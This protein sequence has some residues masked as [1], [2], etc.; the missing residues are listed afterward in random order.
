MRCLLVKF[1]P[2]A[3]YDD[4]IR[5]CHENGLEVAAEYCDEP[6]D[7]GGFL[8]TLDRFRPDFMLCHPHLSGFASLAGAERGILV[9]HWMADKLLSKK[10]FD[11]LKLYDSD[12]ILSTCIE[13]V[14]YIRSVGVKANYVPNVCNIN[15]IDYPRGEAAYGV[16]FVGTVELGENN[17]Y[18]HFIAN[19]D[20]KFGSLSETHAR[21]AE[22]WKDIFAR[23]LETQVEASKYSRYILPEFIDA[24]FEQ[25]SFTEFDKDYILSVLAKEV[26]SM[27]R[28]HF[29]QAVPQLDAFGPEDWGRVDLPN[30]RYRGTCD[31]YHESGQVFARSRINLAVTRVYSM[32]G[33]SDRIFNVLRAG[34]FL[35]ANRQEPLQQMFREGVHLDAY[36]TVEELIDKIRY[37][38]DHPL[39]RER[40][41]QCGLE[42]VLKNHTFGSRIRRILDLLKQPS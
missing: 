22:A 25:S 14:K 20:E 6:G 11:T 41:A 16:S 30:V 24:A 36:T 23:L 32:D 34:G 37:Y 38:E 10:K 28:R 35:L 33:L 2:F 19:L 8:A 5:A 17:Y 9:L 3:Y 1:R 42:E 4:I 15:P 31:Q 7:I 21:V 13:D 26:A 27:Q 12:C 29:I 18:R 39:A 40:I